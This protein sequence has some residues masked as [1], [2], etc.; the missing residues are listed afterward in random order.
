M[1]WLKKLLWSDFTM[2]IVAGLYF[3]TRTPRGNQL[4]VIADTVIVVALIVIGVKWALRKW[5]P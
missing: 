5:R 3:L 1:Q 2:V 4:Q